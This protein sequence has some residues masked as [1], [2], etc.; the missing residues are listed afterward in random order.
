MAV[1]A[2]SAPAHGASPRNLFQASIHRS[3]STQSLSSS[4]DAG[5]R[6]V[7]DLEKHIDDY[8]KG[9][10]YLS[11]RTLPRINGL[12]NKNGNML[13]GYSPDA[14]LNYRSYTTMLSYSN[15]SRFVSGVSGGNGLIAALQNIEAHPG[16]IDTV[17]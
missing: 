5:V 1:E 16:R 4:M 3:Q 7:N 11:E 12:H 10:A 8:R 6:L 13:S 9:R 15:R 17:V 14:L 2:V